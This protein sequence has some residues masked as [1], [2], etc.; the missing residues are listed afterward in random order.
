[1]CAEHALPLGWESRE[2]EEFLIERRRR[3]A[4]IIRVAFRQLGGKTDAP[5]LTSP[6]FLPG[7]EAVW[8]RIA[9]MGR[10]CTI[11]T[12]RHRDGMDKLLLRGEQLKSVARRLFRFRRCTRT[13]QEAHARCDRKGRQTSPVTGARLP[14]TAQ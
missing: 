9:E 6:W 11:C 12:H 3:M 10:S 1:M 5:P 14:E 4:D 13:S 8:Q 2:Y 7:A